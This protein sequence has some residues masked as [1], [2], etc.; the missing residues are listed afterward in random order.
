MIYNELLFTTQISIIFLIYKPII[1][2]LM[3]IQ[4]IRARL[5]RLLFHPWK[6]K[7][8]T[9]LIKVCT[10]RIAALSISCIF[11]FSLPSSISLYHFLSFFDVHEKTKSCGKYTRLKQD[12]HREICK[13]SKKEII[14]EIE[15]MEVI[16]EIK[17]PKKKTNLKGR[18]WR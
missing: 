17:K 5:W 9:P 1:V 11:S 10:L 7:L 18:E 6:K 4:P 12:G 14:F 13:P 8:S 2:T 16:R 3:Y 15:G